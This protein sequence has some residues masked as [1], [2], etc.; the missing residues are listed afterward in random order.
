M[1][2]MA[3]D[4]N[5]LEIARTIGELNGKL[6]EV[7][8]EVRNIAA[9]TEAIGNLV[10]KQEHVPQLIGELKEDM[11]AS[12]ARLDG[13]IDRLKTRVEALEKTDVQTSTVKEALVGFFRSPLPGWLIAA[14][15]AYVSLFERTVS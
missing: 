8:H 5:M 9:R 1:K 12:T 3:E 11:K 10:M 2:V 14:V 7:A 6:G 4:I 13:R 15:V